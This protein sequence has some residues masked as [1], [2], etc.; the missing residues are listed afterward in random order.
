VTCN[1]IKSGEAA[2]LTYVEPHHR[3]P[4]DAGAATVELLRLDSASPLRRNYPCQGTAASPR[5]RLPRCWPMCSARRLLQ[6]VLLLVAVQLL[7]AAAGLDLLNELYVYAA[8]VGIGV[9]P[10]IGCS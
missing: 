3:N 8:L 5:P 7:G 2:A 10:G 1:P 6:R 4:S 9:L